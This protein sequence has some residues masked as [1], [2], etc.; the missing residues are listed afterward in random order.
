M[1]WA[2]SPGSATCVAIQVWLSI[3]EMLESAALRK[4]ASRIGRSSNRA[5]AGVR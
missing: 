4:I 2:A 5:A 1:A 3:Y